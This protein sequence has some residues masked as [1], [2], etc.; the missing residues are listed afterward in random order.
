MCMSLF[1]LIED[2]NYSSK[3]AN[4][5]CFIHH[6]RPQWGRHP[7][8]KCSIIPNS[9]SKGQRISPSHIRT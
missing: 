9:K 4:H 6:A 2:W 8:I 5:Q 3:D 7:I 1:K